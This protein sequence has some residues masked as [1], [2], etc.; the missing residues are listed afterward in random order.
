VLGPR[1][2]GF[3]E[4]ASLFQ[5]LDLADDVVVAIPDGDRRVVT[6]EGPRL[7]SDGLGAMQS[8]LAYRGAEQYSARTGWP[9]GFEVRITKNI[10]VGGGLGGGSADAGAVLR[11]LNAMAPSPLEPSELRDVAAAVGS[12]VAFLATEHASAL[13]SGRGEVLEPVA[14]L[15]VADVVLVIP[16]FGI[17][18]VEAYGWLR[19]ARVYERSGAGATMPAAQER[20]WAAQNLG[21]SFERVVEPRHPELRRF[22]EQLEATVFGLFHGGSATPEARDF[23]L[24]ALVM[25]TRTAAKVVPVEVLE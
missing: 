13:A 16:S 20:A 24:D 10:P 14:T 3:H 8:N 6:V 7:P 4:I 19:Q 23:G 18:T 21:N 12:D 1:A 9:Q 17:S 11:A 25:H 15:P 5:R 2:D 22:R